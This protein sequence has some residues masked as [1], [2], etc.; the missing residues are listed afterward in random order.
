MALKVT[1]ERLLVPLISIPPLAVIVEPV[2]LVVPEN[3][4]EPAWIVVELTMIGAAEEIESPAKATL[5][6]M[7]GLICE[8]TPPIV[9]LRNES[10]ERW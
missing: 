8:L 4:T 2:T 3:E 9:G 5:P 10:I 7:F 1:F 6:P